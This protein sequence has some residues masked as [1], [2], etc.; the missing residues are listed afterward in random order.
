MRTGVKCHS[1]KEKEKGS[2]KS[3]VVSSVVSHSSMD[4][5]EVLNRSGQ[6]ATFLTHKLRS[7]LSFNVIINHFQI[8]EDDVI[9]LQPYT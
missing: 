7:R 5:N 2:E 6:M 1:T 4:R 8:V 9:M 3:N